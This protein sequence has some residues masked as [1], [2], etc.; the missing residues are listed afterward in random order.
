[1][2][3]DLKNYQSSVTTRKSERVQ[4]TEKFLQS[5]FMEI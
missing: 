3:L 1:M 2:I 5:H 4:Y